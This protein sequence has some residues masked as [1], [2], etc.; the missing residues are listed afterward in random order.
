MAEILRF[1]HFSCHC[2]PPLR[3][4]ENGKSKHA[5]ATY[6][7]GSKHYAWHTKRRIRTA[8][9]PQI[10]NPAPAK[11]NKII[12]N[13]ESDAPATQLALV[14]SFARPLHLQQGFCSVLAVRLAARGQ[15]L[16]HRVRKNST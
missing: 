14:D 2:H 16:L 12:Q 11:F 6:S 5:E 13:I 15:T 7:N 4:Q 8:K 1:T 10:A 3:N 9:L